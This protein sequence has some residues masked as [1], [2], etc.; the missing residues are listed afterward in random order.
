MIATGFKEG[1]P[2]LVGQLNF[3]AQFLLPQLRH[4]DSDLFV[5]LRSVVEHVEA[6][7]I[8]GAVAS[9]FHQSHS[10]YVAL[11]LSHCRI[12]HA[13]HFKPGSCARCKGI[14][15]KLAALQHFISDDRAIQRIRKRLANANVLEGFRAGLGQVEGVIIATQAREAERLLRILFGEARILA[16]RNL[17]TIQLTSQITGQRGVFI[18]NDQC[19]HIFNDGFVIVPIRC[20][21]RTHRTLGR[22][23][24]GQYISTV[25][26]DVFRLG[27]VIPMGFDS[28]LW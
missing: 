12:R 4:R 7:R 2:L 10:R 22:Y 9:F 26:N 27:P 11:V 8:V 21:P 23:M 17:G 28:P 25:R 14:G 24:L 13:W 16:S 3:H 1:F 15:L 5:A 20:I 19:H 18:V 6:Q